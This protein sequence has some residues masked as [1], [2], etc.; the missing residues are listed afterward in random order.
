MH[1]PQRM[2][3]LC[4]VLPQL[5][6]FVGDAAPLLRAPLDGVGQALDA[7]FRACHPAWHLTELLY[8]KLLEYRVVLGL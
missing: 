5:L 6:R 2:P 8:R 1:S 4:A 7:V 3:N